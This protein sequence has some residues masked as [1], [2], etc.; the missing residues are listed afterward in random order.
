MIPLEAQYWSVKEIAEVL[1]VSASQVYQRIVCQPTFPKA[2]RI[3]T[4]EGRGH[5]RWKAVEVL[6]WIE[7]A[8]N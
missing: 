7:S 6:E 1:K 4:T 5:P 3:P 2:R 8:P